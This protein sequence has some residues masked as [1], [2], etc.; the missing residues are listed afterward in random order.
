MPPMYYVTMH[1]HISEI[2]IL[3]RLLNADDKVKVHLHW[4]G[5]L[6]LELS[7]YWLDSKFVR[8][9][10]SMEQRCSFD[11]YVSATG[12]KNYC[13]K[14]NT[15]TIT[16]YCICI[17][18]P[19]QMCMLWGRG[20]QKDLI[21]MLHGSDHS[22]QVSTTELQYQIYTLPRSSWVGTYKDCNNFWQERDM[23]MGHILQRLLKQLRI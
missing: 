4:F 5:N 21:N 10:G 13:H 16:S 23:G 20:L 7:N 8:L 22:D 11:M 19:T 14:Q 6:L 17:F 18:P 12:P 2:D 1:T 15:C 9:C 3:Y